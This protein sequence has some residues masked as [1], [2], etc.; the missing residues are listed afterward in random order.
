[1]SFSVRPFIPAD[2]DFVLALLPRLSEVDLPPWCTQAVLDD[3]NLAAMKKAMDDMPEDA[4]LLV[5][6][7]EGQVPAG[8]I[9][10]TTE[11]DYFTGEKLGYISDLV[12]A[13]QAE[14][15]GVGRLLMFAAEDWTREKGYRRLT[16]DVFAG[17]ERARRVYEKAGF[18]PGVVKYAKPID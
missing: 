9:Y 18:L 17:N 8:F 3:F 16:L 11:S 15:Q 10:L 5:A 12:V 4:A 1:M 14:G 2:R 7:D 6:E 13:P